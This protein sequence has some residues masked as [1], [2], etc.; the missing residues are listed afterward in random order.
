MQTEDTGTTAAPEE[1]VTAQPSDTKGRVVFAL[2]VVVA[3]GV[4]L[5]G[6]FG[7]DGPPPPPPP[8]DEDAYVDAL[9]TSKWDVLLPKR[10]F[11]E[12]GYAACELL[13]SGHTEEEATLTMWD[14]HPRTDGIPEE[15]RKRYRQ[16]TL[17][18]HKHLCPDA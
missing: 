12:Q 6:A 5:A 14:R 10:P 17:A 16:Q 8:P 13:R 15:V 2:A 18:A 7:G 11:I 1:P 4:G 9:F 3:V